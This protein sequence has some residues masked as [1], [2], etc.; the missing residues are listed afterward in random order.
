MGLLACPPPE[1]Q[2][3]IGKALFPV[4]QEIG[5]AFVLHFMIGP[6]QREYPW[7]LQILL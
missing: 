5:S 4:S 7:P 2:A 6:F 1:F 3:P